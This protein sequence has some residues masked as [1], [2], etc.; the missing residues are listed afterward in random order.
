[1]PHKQT[2][3]D[4]LSD[5]EALTIFRL[6]LR[7]NLPVGARD[8][9][10]LGFSLDTNRYNK[11]RRIALAELGLTRRP[12]IRRPIR[13]VAEIATRL[14][15]PMVNRQARPVDS[16]TPPTPATTRTRSAKSSLSSGVI[17][18]TA[19]GLPII[20]NALVIRLTMPVARLRALLT[21]SD[22]RAQGG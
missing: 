2:T 17:G 18:S 21:R 20:A 22:I 9:R 14:P 3:G 12:R 19:R 6:R 15:S 7:A 16:S 8:I 5:E 13:D 11:V 4:Y 1:M 10:A